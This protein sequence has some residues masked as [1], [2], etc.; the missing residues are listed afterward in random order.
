M[1]CV[2]VEALVGGL[3]HRM[4]ADGQIPADEELRALLVAG[5]CAE[6]L[7]AA[8]AARD[9]EPFRLARERLRRL[10]EHPEG[11]PSG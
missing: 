4:E 2:P 3:L 1:G 5:C 8:L 11:A 7:D 9:G 6:V 10:L